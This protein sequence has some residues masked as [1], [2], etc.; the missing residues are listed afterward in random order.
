MA[1]S[2]YEAVADSSN[3]NVTATTD[4]WSVDEAGIDE[5][6]LDAS[7]RILANLRTLLYGEPMWKLIE[8]QVDASEAQ[9]KKWLDESNGEYRGGR[10]KLR[11]EG[12]TVEQ[13]FGSIMKTMGAALAEGE[14]RRQASIDGVFPAHPEHYG[15]ALDGPGGVETMGGMPTLT[16]PGYITDDAEIPDFIRPLIDDSY[17]LSKVGKGLLRDGSVQS[18]VLQQFRDADGGIDA[19]LDIWYPAACPESVVEE[20]LRHYSVEFRNGVRLARGLA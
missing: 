7:R 4:G 11:I 20:H 16:Y 17:Q 15:L 10:V 8:A 12:L 2:G 18:Y 13:L 19:C 3:S 9:F 14:A 1:D 5:F 6:E